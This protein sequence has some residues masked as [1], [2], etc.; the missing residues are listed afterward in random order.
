MGDGVVFGNRCFNCLRRLL[1][2]FIYN[3]RIRFALIPSRGDS[4]T[5]VEATM[6][7]VDT[8]IVAYVGMC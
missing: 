5:Y 7:V 4:D 6:K 1:P 8:I 3:H 2:L